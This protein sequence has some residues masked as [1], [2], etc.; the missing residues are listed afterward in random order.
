MRTFAIAVHAA[1]IAAVLF[2]VGCRRPGD[3]ERSLRVFGAA[4]LTDVLEALVD[5]FETD[6]GEDEFV[7]LHLAGSSLLARQIEHGAAADVIISAHPAW[8][9]YLH[10]RGI[11]HE[12]HELSIT[13]RLVLVGRDSSPT[14]RNVERLALADPAHVPAGV[15]ARAALE[16]ENLWTAISDRV[17]A[18]IDVRAA[19]AAVHEG[20]ADA[21]IVYES[22]VRFAPHLEVSFPFSA[23]CTPD[24]IY[25]I[26]VVCTADKRAEDFA[27]YL[28]DSA[29]LPTWTAFGF[30]ARSRRIAR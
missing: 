7:R 20:A 25:E 18:V 24:V 30:S 10:Q 28:L 12:P 27:N 2:A 9:S 21:A 4:S 1:V 14:L 22:D 17:A 3:S 11:I 13:N 29:R 8:T 23:G 26:G 15:Y 16:C 19:L 6:A 5:S